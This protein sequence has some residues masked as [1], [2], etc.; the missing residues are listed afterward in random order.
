MWV[1][2]ALEK[3]F[4]KAL[5]LRDKWNKIALE[6]FLNINA[7]I[8]NLHIESKR[9]GGYRM[10]QQP[11]VSA[12]IA[13]AGASSR[14][15]GTDKQK[16]SL[17]GLPVIIRTLQEFER[18][19]GISE[20]ILVC[21]NH[22]LEVF[23]SLIAKHQLTKVSAVVGGGLTRQSSVFAGIA[24]CSEQAQYYAIHDGAR[25]LVSQKVIEDVLAGAFQYGGAAPGIAAK[26]TIK[27]V[28]KDGFVNSTPPR[29]T[30]RIIQT[31]QVFDAQLYGKAMGLAAQHGLDYTDDCQLFEAAGQR[32][33]ITEGDSANIKITFPLDMELSET[34]LRNL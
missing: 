19:V 21:P 18:N 28:S 8:S 1:P 22:E 25:P 24:A 31:P 13:A 34:I 12:I 29:S 5:I 2:I 15:E 26:E 11:F 10:S 4:L 33:F 16:A 27:I 7:I 3:I 30:V 6:P 14:M 23:Q 9:I 17:N 20:I 32:V